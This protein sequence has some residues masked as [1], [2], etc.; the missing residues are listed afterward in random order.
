[1]AYANNLHKRRGIQR[2]PIVMAGVL[3]SLKKKGFKNATFSKSSLNEDMRKHIDFFISLGE[4]TS[5]LPFTENSV[6]PIDIKT[7]GSFTLY[8]DKGFN[9][10]EKCESEYLVYEFGEDDDSY[11]FISVKALKQAIKDQPP[12]LRRGKYDNSKYFWMT[13][14]I[15]D[16]LFE[17][18]ELFK[19]KK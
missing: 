4:G 3:N 19:L 8:S 9:S 14:Y 11:T 10:L 18:D 7:K 2:E 1:M 6:I 15:E 16:V 12:A 17:K 5:D 13:N